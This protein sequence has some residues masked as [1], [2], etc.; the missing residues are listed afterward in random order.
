MKLGL[1]RIS[2]VLTLLGITMTAAGCGGDDF[3]VVPPGDPNAPPGESTPPGSTDTTPDPN[4]PNNPNNP[5]NPPPAAK[6]PQVV[7]SLP[8]DNAKGVKDD[9]TIVLKFDRAMDMPSVENAYVSLELPK[10]QVSFKWSVAHDEVTIVPAQKLAYSTG[11]PDVG[12]NGYGI[13]IGKSAKSEAGVPM[14]AD[15]AM[16]F[17]TLRRVT[18]TPPRVG[19]LSGR[20]S[21]NGTTTTL[22][23]AIGDFYLAGNEVQMRGFLTFD[24]KNIPDAEIEKATLSMPED[25]MT[26]TP[27]LSLGTF[28]GAQVFYASLGMDAFNTE[29]VSGLTF[30]RLLGLNGNPSVRFADATAMVK[31]DL[32]NRAVRNNRTQIRMTYATGTNNDA[33][34]D[35]VNLDM[36]AGSLKV[37]YLAP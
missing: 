27:D 15:F 35:S 18:D 1:A 21:S 23:C 19:V 16:A 36:V 13:T 9:A 22:A 26:G 6:A 5:S 4:N 29:P 17:T 11:G 12:A 2:I 3:E 14:D 20:V 7:S 10:E 34:T 32:A 31:D 30:M 28:S 24:L 37:T 33:T 25:N 8:L